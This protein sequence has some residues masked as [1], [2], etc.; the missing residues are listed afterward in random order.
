[1]AAAFVTPN[2]PIIQTFISQAKAAIGLKTED[3]IPDKVYNAMLLFD[4]MIASQL[5]Y[6]PDPNNPFSQMQNKQAL[7]HLKYPRETLLQGGGD[8]DDLA[9]LYCSLLE[10]VGIKT[11]L[12]D[13][14]QHLFMM[15]DTAIPPE[16]GYKLSTDKNMYVVDNNSI[17]IPV[18][19]T[20]LEKGF[21]EA[22]QIAARNYNKWSS[23]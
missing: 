18:E 12:V 20:E 14:P 6:I 11:K 1:M 16:R 5:K 23:R 13:V 7:D 9:V 19:V 2:D 8:C 3:I 21:I 15:F 4:T 22:W 10:A 17:W